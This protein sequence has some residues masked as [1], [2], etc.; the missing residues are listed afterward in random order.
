MLEKVDLTK[1]I[2]KEKYKEKM[3][4]L[5]S[6]L[7]RLQRECK[8]LGIP[9]LIVF[10]GF[11]AAGK[12]LQIGH[13]IQSM[14]PRGFE[15][16]P[17]KNETEEERMHPFM[18]RFWTKTPARGRIAIFDGSWYRKVLIDRF[19]KRTKAKDLPAAF[20]SINSFEQQL[21][22]DGNL[23]I[24]LFLDIDKKEQ[25][26]RFDK[27][28]KNKETAWRVSQGDR[29][30]N[31]HYDE[32]AALM[33]DMLFNTDTDYAPW[34]IVESMDRRFATLKIYT[35]V[36]KA[37]ADQIEKVQQQNI[38]KAVEKADKAEAEGVVR[39]KETN[40]D[41]I[42]EIA[43]EADAQMKDLQVS[44]LSKADLSLSYTR[45][46]YKE[47][48]DKLQKKMEKL[49][50][51]LYRRRIPV[52]LGFEGWDAGGKGGAIKRLTAKMDARG[53]VVNPTASPND[54]EKAH[55]YLWRFWRAMPKDGHVAIFDRTWY[56]RV[57]VERIEGFCTTEEWKRAYKEINDMEK[58]LYNAGAIVIKFW[59]HID[60]DE[61]ER[62]FK[63]RQ[64]NPEKQ[65]KITDEDW[66][67]REKWDQYEDAVNEMLMRTSTDYAPWVVVEGNSKYY[68]RVKVLQ[69][70]VDAIEKRLKEE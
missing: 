4:Q 5:E 12:G 70:V 8:A 57:M 54:I 30:R 34:T 37:M 51:E 25:K 21:A 29:E 39:K 47:K 26:K 60:K 50:G 2:S 67:N 61:Q 9:V 31:A 35:T 24:K 11:G 36:I 17:V 46:E 22:D 33:E 20:H 18:W 23:I 69:T 53:Y 68:A 44:I 3:P 64:E 28:A 1:K 45:E 55:H 40:G 59:M 66:R 42:E 38:A 16:H 63:E 52:V 65:W 43:R 15:V 49:H 14:D 19:E 58:D 62:R 27:L 7:G 6:K 10:E 32:Y 13:L 48:L 41:E 56:G